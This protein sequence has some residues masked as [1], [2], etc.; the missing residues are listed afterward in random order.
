M[1]SA[2]LAAQQGVRVEMA[3]NGLVSAS[4]MSFP[5][6]Q[7]SVPSNGGNSAPSAIAPPPS[8]GP[9]YLVADA[10]PEAPPADAPLDEPVP[11]APPPD[12]PLPDAP[13]PNGPLPDAPPPPAHQSL[14]HSPTGD[15]TA[16]ES[17]SSSSS[18]APPV[19]VHPPTALATAVSILEL[20]APLNPER[21]RADA[22]AALS[23][24]EEWVPTAPPPALA[25]SADSL[26]A[27][28]LFLT[29]DD[30]LRLQCLNVTSQLLYKLAEE[31][32]TP[33]DDTVTEGWWRALASFAARGDLIR[34]AHPSVAMGI[35][36]V[37][38]ALAKSAGGDFLSAL[39][40]A[41]PPFL[42]SLAVAADAAGFVG[43][44][45]S[46]VVA[47]VRL[48]RRLRKAGTDAAH[49]ALAALDAATSPTTAKIVALLNKAVGENVVLLLLSRERQAAVEAARPGFALAPVPVSAYVEMNP[50]D[51]PP[52]EGGGW[53]PREMILSVSWA[54]L[55]VMW[56]E[57]SIKAWPW[58]DVTGVSLVK[59]QAVIGVTGGGAGLPLKTMWLRVGSAATW[60]AAASTVM[61]CRGPSVKVECDAGVI[62]NPDPMREQAWAACA[63][64]GFPP[65][66]IGKSPASQERVEPKASQPRSEA[67][68]PQPRSDASERQPRSDASE[69]QPQQRSEPRLR[70]S[71][72]AKPATQPPPQSQVPPRS[73]QKE[74]EKVDVWAVP[75]DPPASPAQHASDPGAFEE[76]PP[77]P[78]SYGSSGSSPIQARRKSKP[79]TDADPISPGPSPPKPPPSRLPPPVRPAPLS[80]KQT[81]MSPLVPAPTPAVRRGSSRFTNARAPTRQPAKTVVRS[82]NFVFD[83]ETETPAPRRASS[84]VPGGK[85]PRSMPAVYALSEDDPIEEVLTQTGARARERERARNLRRSPASA[86][87]PPPP[88]PKPKEA[89]DPRTAPV[90]AMRKPY[91]E[92]RDAAPPGGS[93]SEP[94]TTTRRVFSNSPLARMSLAGGGDDAA[95]PSPVRRPPPHR[96][97]VSDGG[98]EIPRVV[99]AEP[100]DV[101]LPA[102][103]PRSGLLREAQERAFGGAAGR[104]FS[105]PASDRRSAVS[106]RMTAARPV[107]IVPRNLAPTTG[108]VVEDLMAAT[109]SLVTRLS[110]ERS[111]E[112]MR[113]VN[114]T[115]KESRAETE[116]GLQR[117]QRVAVRA[118]RADVDRCISARDTPLSASNTAAIRQSAAAF[119][120]V[121]E[122]VRSELDAALARVKMSAV[123]A[124]KVSAEAQDALND[125]YEDANDK[126][127]SAIAQSLTRLQRGLGMAKAKMDEASPPGP[128]GVVVVGVA[129][130]R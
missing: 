9:E 49:G 85:R 30:R 100:Q 16:S 4:Y 118:V 52:S 108:N 128:P 54:G 130:A 18:P 120:R 19:P 42:A 119:E 60:A 109:R 48:R 14:P 81:K 39:G 12:E 2:D 83:N 127:T 117:L 34:V 93:T 43:V 36:D 23:T 56:E 90:W 126:V 29:T 110:F 80:A 21:A 122:R 65:T 67:S 104:F 86:V 25:A 123:A 50:G 78:P 96:G 1:G 45:V 17:S 66:P 106:L 103:P 75:D 121:V 73:Q 40:L 62:T 115:V 5:L 105:E 111:Q 68:E 82:D 26:L 129:A 61:A 22:A 27:S 95:S 41:L 53:V 70:A 15:T 112:V 84:R 58:S 94:P 102:S 35:G 31:G 97:E 10:I 88:P 124:L 87:L 51:A 11:D 63:N 20:A 92:P 99:R 77:P 98:V 7:P 3:S 116:D 6:G 101:G 91:V 55:Q 72:L 44:Q 74:E 32:A 76:A 33:L 13:P 24:V 8:R 59:E 114:R 64:G 28:L 69:P 37:I 79:A 71:Q 47:L 107:S 125:S 89:F 113:A 46:L 57:E 38:N